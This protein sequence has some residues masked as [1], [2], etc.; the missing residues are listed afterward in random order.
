MEPEVS[1]AMP[2]S[3]AMFPYSMGFLEGSSRADGFSLIIKAI[4]ILPYVGRKADWL[5]LT[6]G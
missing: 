3:T 5:S 1:G 4:V 2:E 6:I